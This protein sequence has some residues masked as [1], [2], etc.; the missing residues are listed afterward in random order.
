MIPEWNG[1]ALSAIDRATGSA[2]VLVADDLVV[3]WASTSCATVLGFDPL[4]MDAVGL[5]HPEDVDL[6]AAVLALRSTQDAGAA[7]TDAL[8]TAPPPVVHLRV[9]DGSGGWIDCELRIEDRLHDPA[10]RAL[11]IQA[12]RAVDRSG[13]SRALDGVSRAA[14]I[15]ETL[16]AVLDHLAEH[17]SP[18][19]D[20]V[21]AVL[22]ETSDGTRALVTRASEDD[23]RILFGESVVG[24]LDC[25][26]PVV[27]VPPSTMPAE[28]QDAVAARGLTHLWM[29]RIGDPGE[30][31]GLLLSWSSRRHTLELRPHAHLTLGRDLVRLAL[32]EHNRVT[33]LRHEARFDPLT[34]VMNRSGLVDAH[35]D[36]VA[37]SPDRVGVVFVDLDDF[38]RVN[39]THGHA[40]GD[41]VLVEIG[42]RLRE[43]VRSGDAVGRIGGDEFVILCPGADASAVRSVADRVERAFAREIHTDAG[44]IR[45]HASLGLV[46]LPGTTELEVLVGEADRDQYRAKRSARGDRTSDA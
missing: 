18:V 1:R 41:A 46:S 3:R 31:L 10:V 25:P 27:V 9:T 26:D 17:G 38:K 32:L 12:T 35:A 8:H 11:V 13:L 23:A 40:V 34:D 28:V 42:A 4:G 43:V 39:D 6:A 21:A 24:S 33:S 22:R 37:R 29:I 45:V 20:H 16:L 44:W 2:T 14:P 36:M 5:L 15:E 30:R 7:A 19:A